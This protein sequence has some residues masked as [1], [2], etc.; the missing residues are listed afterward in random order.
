MKFP[1][2]IFLLEISTLDYLIYKIRNIVS[3]KFASMFVQT[4]S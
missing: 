3:D 4:F 1:Y 2:G